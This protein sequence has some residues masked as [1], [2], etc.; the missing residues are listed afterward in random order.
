MTIF[1]IMCLFVAVAM[2][3][4]G[5]WW[6]VITNRS[7]ICQGFFSWSFRT[8][9]DLFDLFVYTRFFRFSARPPPD[10]VMASRV[11]RAAAF[12]RITQ[13]PQASVA[14]ALCRWQRVI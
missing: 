4:S 12:A 9:D 14:I 13:P 7:E 8:L 3:V 5:L 6:S 1:A 2:A 11:N 10:D